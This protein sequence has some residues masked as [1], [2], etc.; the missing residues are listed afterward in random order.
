MLQ[1]MVGDDSVGDEVVCVNIFD[2]PKVHS[3]ET[4]G[5]GPDEPEPSNVQSSVCPLLVSSHVSVSCGP[6]QMR[7][8]ASVER[9]R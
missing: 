4:I 1:S 9:S 3:H 5:F 2:E 6:R 8:V 7:R